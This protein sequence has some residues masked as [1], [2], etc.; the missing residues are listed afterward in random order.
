MPALSEYTNVYNTALL[1]LQKKGF[2]VWLDESIDMYC[3]EKDGWD[4]MAQTPCGLLGVVAIF[5]YKQPSEYREYWWQ[6]QGQDIYSNLPRQPRAY[7]PV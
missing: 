1:I 7:K 2:Q 5:E 4:F 6:E 3:A